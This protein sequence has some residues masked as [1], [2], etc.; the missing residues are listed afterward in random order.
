MIIQCLYIL[1]NILLHFPSSLCIYS[2][3]HSW[4]NWD[5]CL[6]PAQTLSLSMSAVVYEYDHLVTVSQSLLKY[7]NV[8]SRP[9]VW[10]SS[11]L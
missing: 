4:A 9:I 10:Y 5:S 1:L 2:A 8:L 7:W 6:F 11:I 3:D